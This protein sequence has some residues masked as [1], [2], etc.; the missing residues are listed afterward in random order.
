MTAALYRGLSWVRGHTPSCAILAVSTPEIRPAGA[1]A[2]TADSGY[3]YYSA[4]TEREVFFESWVLTIQGQNGAQPYPGLYA[5]NRAATP[6]G[7][8]AAVRELA[9]RGVSYILSDKSHG[10]DV[11]EP[12]SVGRLVFA[13]SALGVYRLTVPVSH[14]GC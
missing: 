1:T 3:F 5:L 7:S 13:N 8:P 12:P 4:F 2:T 10:G 11:R 9:R 14:H 6:R